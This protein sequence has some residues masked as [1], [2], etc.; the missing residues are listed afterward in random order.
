MELLTS[1]LRTVL[2][3]Q[4]YGNQRESVGVGGIE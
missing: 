1:A 2:E 4:Y 3:C